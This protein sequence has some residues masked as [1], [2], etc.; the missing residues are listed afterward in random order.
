[1]TRLWWPVR[2]AAAEV[3]FLWGLAA[4][5]LRP[6]DMLADARRWRWQRRQPCWTSS[7]GSPGAMVTWLEANGFVLDL[8]QRQV[9]EEAFHAHVGA[10]VVRYS[11]AGRDG[12]RMSHQANES[13]QFTPMNTNGQTAGLPVADNYP[14]R[15]AAGQDPVVNPSAGTQGPPGGG[16]NPMGPAPVI[17]QSV[18]AF[19]DRQVYPDTSKGTPN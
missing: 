15:D 12:D 1:M 17:G 3:R 16:V 2:R 4:Y 10:A 13:D 18:T 8:W 5:W 14:H 9:I 7:S 19:S 6:Y 11:A